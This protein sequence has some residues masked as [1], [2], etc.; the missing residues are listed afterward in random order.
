MQRSP[1]PIRV[2]K[3]QK[4]LRLVFISVH[5][6]LVAAFYH[7]FNAVRVRTECAAQLFDVPVDHAVR[8]VKIPAPRKIK[9]LVPRQHAVFALH[10]RP[11]QSKFLG[12]QVDAPAVRYDNPPFRVK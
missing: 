6:Q 5:L 9:Q 3:L 11:Q 2:K 10:Q 7:G 1:A 8:A 12:R 4:V